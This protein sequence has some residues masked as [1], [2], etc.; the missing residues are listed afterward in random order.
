MVRKCTCFPE[1][2]AMTVGYIPVSWKKY[3][4]RV[5]TLKKKYW[6]KV[7]C[8]ELIEM[9]EKMDLPTSTWT[10][11]SKVWINTWKLY[12][13]SSPGQN[14]RHFADGIFKCIFMNEKSCISIRISL[15]FVRKGPID[16]TLALVQIMAC[17]LF[18]WPSS[19][20]HICGTWGRWVKE[21]HQKSEG[22]LQGPSFPLCLQHWFHWKFYIHWRSDGYI[23][24]FLKICDILLISIHQVTKW[25]SYFWKG[26]NDCNGKIIKK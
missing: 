20:T 12:F 9:P 24:V 22:S 5:V 11:I 10:N 2:S 16:N 13:T 19:L 8:H 1:K 3:L 6:K 18:G 17:R 4:V 23:N 15:K 14:G 21:T 26:R 25:N 7:K